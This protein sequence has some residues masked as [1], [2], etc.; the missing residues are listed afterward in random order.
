MHIDDAMLIDGAFRPDYFVQKLH[1]SNQNRQISA[2]NQLKW[3]IMTTPRTI[4]AVQEP[5]K[6]I[7][8][9]HMM[10]IDDAM[11]IDGAFRPDYLMQK[12][13]LGNQD[14][15]IGAPNQLK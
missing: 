6:C 4:N 1:L 8:G 13:H 10:H 2:P 9:L 12:L 3:A 14:R 7:E 11:L 15:Q 5:T